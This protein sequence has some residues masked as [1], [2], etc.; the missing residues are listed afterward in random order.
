[1][2]ANVKNN[3][4]IVTL[5]FVLA[6]GNIPAAW[7]NVDG[8]LEEKVTE[9][10][11]DSRVMQAFTS[12]EVKDSEIVAIEDETKRLVMFIL[13]VPP[14]NPADCYGDTGYCYGDIW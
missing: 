6:I 4:K 10:Q 2:I 13:G 11:T 14:V 12:N 5:F 7:A 3:V 8:S 1:M 9:D